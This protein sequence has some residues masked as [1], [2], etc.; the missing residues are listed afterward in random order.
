MLKNDFERCHSDAEP[1]EA[2]ES[3]SENRGLARF[4]VVSVG[5]RTDGLL[6]MTVRTGFS[7]CC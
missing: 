4:L 3:R 7:A 5:R 2:E 1:S 6:E